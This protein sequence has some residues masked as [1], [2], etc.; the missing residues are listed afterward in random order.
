MQRTPDPEIK[1]ATRRLITACGGVDAA[2]AASGLA[3]STI[4][5][6]QAAHLL[7]H[8][9]VDVAFVLEQ[10]AGAPEL[11]RLLALRHGLALVPVDAAPAASLTRQVSSLFQEAAELGAAHADALTD[12][13]IDAAERQRIGREAADVVRAASEI[14]GACK[15]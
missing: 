12:G 5:E 14:M 4:A 2:A 9:P 8:I 15:P 3:R 6:Y 10:F 1:A 11:T 7:A 13:I